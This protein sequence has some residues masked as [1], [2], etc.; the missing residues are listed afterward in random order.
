VRSRQLDLVER[1]KA[2][3]PLAFEALV[4]SQADQLMAVAFRILRDH[5]RAEDAVQSALVT[6]WQELPRLRNSGSFDGW[7]RRV[8]VN[9]C[10][11]EFRDSRQRASVHAI[12][13]DGVTQDLVGGVVD[14]DVLSRGFGRLPIDQRVVLTYRFYLGFPVEAIAQE[15]AL[16]I[17]TVK[18]RLYYAQSALRAAIEANERPRGAEEVRA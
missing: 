3:D 10:Y 8:L 18:S 5:D 6:A 12:H 15:L 4:A 16:P 1:S 17:G 7:L 11:A 14:R 13:E 9:A 2:G